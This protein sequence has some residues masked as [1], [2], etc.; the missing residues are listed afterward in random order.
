MICIY[1]TPGESA[2]LEP[3]FGFCWFR[4]NCSPHHGRCFMFTE[5]CYNCSLH[6][7]RMLRARGGLS[8]L[9]FAITEDA[10]H[11]RSDNSCNLEVLQDPFS[12][13]FPQLQNVMTRSRRLHFGRFKVQSV[14]DIHGY[15]LEFMLIVRIFIWVIFLI[16]NVTGNSFVFFNGGF[17]FLSY[18]PPLK[19][20]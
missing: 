9:F 11:L 4:P 8:E 6:W 15:T 7:W 16:F 1:R 13:L 2:T 17:N 12:T 10:P 14:W 19:V 18:R 5:D 3:K 20:I